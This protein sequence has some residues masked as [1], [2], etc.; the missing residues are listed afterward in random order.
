MNKKR[1]KN[2]RKYLIFVNKS[3]KIKKTHFF[4]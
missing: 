4:S 1:K 3:E 2:H